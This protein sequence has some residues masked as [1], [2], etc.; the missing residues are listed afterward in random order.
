ME[1]RR[2]VP[3]DRGVLARAGGRHD[4]CCR[5]GSFTRW[6][7]ADHVSL[8]IVRFRGRRGSQGWSCA[9]GWPGPATERHQLLAGGDQL[10]GSPDRVRCSLGA[11]RGGRGVRAAGA[12]PRYRGRARHGARR[13][14]QRSGRHGCAVGRGAGLFAATARDRGPV[15][16]PG[17]AGP[18]P[19]VAGGE[20]C[21][22][23]DESRPGC[24]QVPAGLPA[25][26][27]Q[28]SSLLSPPS[29]V[30]SRTGP[31]TTAGPARGPGRAV[32]SAGERAA[33]ALLAGRAGYVRVQQRGAASRA[34][35]R[36][37]GPL[38]QPL[39]QFGVAERDGRLQAGARLHLAQIHHGIDQARWLP[40]GTCPGAAG[41]QTRAVPAA[42]WQV[43]TAAVAIV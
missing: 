41:S 5:T 37:A 30:F 12:R 33:A 28:A 36:I 19:S 4:R 10:P 14:T 15:S 18:G 31:Q 8:C 43:I 21:R 23:R 29:D 1:S 3:D 39:G 17:D 2:I 6:T 38:P 35:D 24:D 13:G 27:R 20:P 11:H 9:P 16:L 40:G 42:S 22:V 25:R 34:R 32:R 26:A 7:R